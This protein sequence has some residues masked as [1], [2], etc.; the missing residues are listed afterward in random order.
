M[1]QW[2][3]KWTCE[4]DKMNNLLERVNKLR[5]DVSIENP[6]H[7]PIFENIYMRPQNSSITEGFGNL[8]GFI[9]P[10]EDVFDEIEEEVQKKISDSDFKIQQGWDSSLET[11]NFASGYVQSQINSTFNDLGDLQDL[12]IGGISDAV[13]NLSVQ[14]ELDTIE[15]IK[16]NFKLPVGAIKKSI[17]TIIVSIYTLSTIFGNMIKIIGQNIQLAKLYLQQMIIQ[18]NGILREALEAIARVLTNEKATKKEIDIFQDQTGKF[19][20]MLLIWFFVYNWY[21]V[22][23]FIQEE[24][25]IRYKFNTREMKIMNP[26]LYGAIGPAFR[27]IEIFNSSIMKVGNYIQNKLKVWNAL[28][29]FVMFWI[30]FILVNMN[31]QTSILVNFFNAISG[32]YSFTLITLLAIVVIAYE[33]FT[34]FWGE[35]KEQKQDA[36]GNWQ[37]TEIPTGNMQM[38]KLSQGHSSGIMA[39]GFFMLTL[40][41]FLFYVF[42]NVAVNIPAGLLF[43]T[44]YLFIYTFLSVPFYEGMDAAFIY[45]NITDSIDLENN[46]LTQEYCKPENDRLFTYHWWT[47]SLPILIKE[48][49]IK[50]VNRTTLHLFEIIIL[51]ILLGGIGIY[52]KEWTSS[53]VGKPQLNPLAPG[54]MT[55]TFESLFFWLILINVLIIIIVGMFLYNKIKNM[56]E[57]KKGASNIDKDT[58]LNLTARSQIA[59]MNPNMN[60]QQKIKKQK[61][62]DET[63]E[64]KNNKDLKDIK[65]KTVVEGTPEEKTSEEKTSEEKTSKGSLFSGFFGASQNKKNTE[66]PEGGGGK[67]I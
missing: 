35:Q 50:I 43:I 54:G 18:F 4:T 66:E 1:N 3:K 29:F 30:F 33:S 9:S 24:D 39:G 55:Q 27:V 67:K 64:D 14:Q 34:W 53:L 52:N 44:T 25:D 6:K 12:S 59:K 63:K 46:D 21:Y 60:S 65:E 36:E 20:T 7:I 19:L 22:V 47:Y 49:G 10:G 45:S 2:K 13:N 38:F 31:F 32:Q 16:D 56:E 28:I 5:N 15:N 62:F 26:L 40:F 17:E 58:K 57:L 42:W 8:E 51:L 61:S 41:L 23:F 11:K 37:P 48:F